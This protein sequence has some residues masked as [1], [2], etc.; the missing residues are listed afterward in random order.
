MLIRFI[1]AYYLHGKPVYVGSSADPAS[2]AK[3]HACNDG[4]PFQRFMAKHGPQ[5]FTLRLVEAFRAET[6]GELWQLS[7]ARENQWMDVLGTWH[8]NGGQNFA[9]ARVLFNS[10]E[11]LDARNAAISAA[12]RKWIENN[13]NK[14]LNAPGVR[15]KGG[16]IQV[17]NSTGMFAPKH[18]GKGGRASICVQMKNGIGI[19]SP[20]HQGCGARANAEHWRRKNITAAMEL[21]LNAGH[22]E[23][24]EQMRVYL[25]GLQNA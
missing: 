1:Y 7:A 19:F 18:R 13:P 11:I 17:T 22:T 9:R 24:A 2:R 15:G 21:M 8:E 16:R 12:A 6:V 14:G 10:A 4:I 25:E 5:H 3:N 23:T 20:E